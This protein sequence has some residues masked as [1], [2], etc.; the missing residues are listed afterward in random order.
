MQSQSNL[1]GLG[2]KTDTATKPRVMGGDRVYVQQDNPILVG[3]IDLSY[4]H[5]A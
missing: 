5:A 2:F 4:L 1:L 3:I